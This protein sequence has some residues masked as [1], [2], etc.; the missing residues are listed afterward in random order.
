MEMRAGAGETS[1]LSGR[2]RG[3]DGGDER[4]DVLL[5]VPLVV[6]AMDEIFVNPWRER[7]SRINES[8]S[9]IVRECRANPAGLLPCVVDDDVDVNVDDDEE[10]G[11]TLS[12]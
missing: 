8:R 6:T 12:G 5:C 11:S 9:A 3:D 1:A 4:G 2:E 7:E 10:E